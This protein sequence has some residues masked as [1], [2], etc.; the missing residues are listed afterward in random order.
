MERTAHS[1]T[2]K[3]V[4]TA[5]AAAMVATIAPAA[6][7]TA[8]MV[9]TIAPAAAI[10]V[11]GSSDS[12]EIG[13]ESAYAASTTEK[14]ATEAA[15][16]PSKAPYATELAK[17]NVSGWDGSSKVVVY[18]GFAKLY[19][20]GYDN[21][22]NFSADSGKSMAE[23]LKGCGGVTKAGVRWAFSGGKTY[24]D[25]NVDEE[26]REVVPADGCGTLYIDCD[27]AFEEPLG[28][29]FR[30]IAADHGGID[31]AICAKNIVVG[32]HVTELA[33][34]SMAGDHWNDDQVLTFEEPS[35]LAKV[36]SYAF[37]RSGFKSIAFPSSL[38]E[39]AKNAFLGGYPSKI[40]YADPSKVTVDTGAYV[41]PA[42][43]DAPAIKA[44]GKVKK[45]TAGKRAL[46]VTMKRVSGAK[47]Y[48]VYYAQAGQT[49]YKSKLVKKLTSKN[50]TKTTVT[51]KLAKLK[52]GKQYKVYYI[53]YSKTSAKK[54][55][56][57]TRTPAKTSPKVK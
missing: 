24:V 54:T 45:V 43:P 8:A 44:A 10:C 27:G 20:D 33:N 52:K 30:A 2:K 18:D 39:V 37:D 46:T 40:T 7:L 53:A 26:D 25:M 22:G 19:S 15:A 4:A 14:L 56:A 50:S 41:Y 38:K 11:A 31:F 32:R 57:I 42:H 13:V 36:A 3:I 29:N 51:A 5:L 34:R 16:A 17:R 6:A 12:S 49:K 35:S 9:A 1:K 48:R 23:L 55:N 28:S 47:A 21:Y